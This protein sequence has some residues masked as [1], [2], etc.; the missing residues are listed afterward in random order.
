MIAVVWVQAEKDS[1]SCR[2]P[3][4]QSGPQSGLP[5]ATCNSRRR[6]RTPSSVDSLYSYT[7]HTAPHTHLP[8]TS[9]P[10]S[11]YHETPLP[12]QEAR[13]RFRPR[14]LPSIGHDHYHIYP[15]AI[16]TRSKTRVHVTSAS[17][18]PHPSATVIST[19][20]LTK[21][22]CWRGIRISARRVP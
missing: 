4:S 18:R 21:R 13:F 14:S 5:P 16:A 6:P 3:R 15:T 10:T 12:Q 17:P 20:N 22:D 7:S 2:S 9:R 19:Q 1:G 8:T 11:S